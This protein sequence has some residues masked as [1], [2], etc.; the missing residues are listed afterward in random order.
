MV[1]SRSGLL[2]RAALSY[3]R[4]YAERRSVSMKKEGAESIYLLFSLSLPLSLSFP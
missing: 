4:G 1:K 2:A 3:P